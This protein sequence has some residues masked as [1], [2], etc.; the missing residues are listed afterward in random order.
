MRHLPL[1]FVALC[2]FTQ[3]QPDSQPLPQATPLKFFYE[4]TKCADPWSANG[5]SSTTEP[6]ALLEDYLTNLDIKYTDFQVT[7]DGT[8]PTNCPACTCTTGRIFRLEAED[9]YKDKLLNLGFVE[10]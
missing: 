6:E 9:E 10:E 3:C 1:A 4:E 7:L 5:Q 2:L 8:A